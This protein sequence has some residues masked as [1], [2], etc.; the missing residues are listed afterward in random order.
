MKNIISL[1]KIH[2]PFIF[3]ASFI[4]YQSHQPARVV[5]YDG[6]TNFLLHKFAHVIVYIFLFLTATRS[7][8]DL[9]KA[10]I[11]TVL[12]ALSDEYHQSFIQTRTSSFRDVLIDS[13]S[14]GILFL[15]LKNYRN[16]IPDF[17]RKFLR[18]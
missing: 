11:F 5:A 18:I 17:L 2:I 12:Y 3:M 14:A 15:I 10:F 4:F 1:F 6:E 8:K 16:K 7:F 9:K 13:V